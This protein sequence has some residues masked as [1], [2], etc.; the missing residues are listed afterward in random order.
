M[1]AYLAG[2]TVIEVDFAN[3]DAEDRVVA[4]LRFSNRWDRPTV[5]EWVRVVDAEGNTC[6]GRVEAL[7]KL[8]VAIRLDPATWSSTTVTR[9]YSGTASATPTFDEPVTAPDPDP[10]PSLA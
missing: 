9:T 4:S 8:I 1:S 2:E 5:G 10:A 6:V 7:R 3:V